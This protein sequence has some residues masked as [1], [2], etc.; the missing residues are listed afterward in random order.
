MADVLSRATIHS[1]SVQLGI[2]Y[3]ATA[4]A[5]K[6]KEAKT[7]RTA[8]T[9]FTLQDVNFDVSDETILCDISTGYLRPIVL[10]NF[11]RKVFEVIHN[12]LHPSVRC[13]RDLVSEKFMWCDLKKQ[14]SMLA[15]SC[16]VCR[17]SITEVKH[18]RTTAYHPQAN[19][20]VE[21]FHWPH[22]RHCEPD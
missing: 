4:A 17:R 16:I 10:L 3:S 13:T 21:R 14:V 19:C 11:C 6:S 1:I 15:K 22:D 12:L 8:I 5:Q 9:R 20:L 2:D 18:S 7:C